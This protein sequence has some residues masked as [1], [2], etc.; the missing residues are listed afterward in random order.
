[1]SRKSYERKDRLSEL[2]REILSETL[3]KLDN[4]ELEYVA[5]TTVEVDNNLN[6]AN[7]LINPLQEN[8]N[9][10]KILSALEKNIPEFLKS[11]GQARFKQ[12]PELVFL[13]DG[14]IKATRKIEEILKELD[15][16]T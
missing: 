7:I 9:E 14:G 13:I 4:P 6:R 2:I 8:A 11:L 16:E 3:R 15:I 12:M 10:K 5:I 1:M